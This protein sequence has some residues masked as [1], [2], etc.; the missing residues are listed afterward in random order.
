MTSV[1]GKAIT[2]AQL[3]IR[4]KSVLEGT[5]SWSDAEVGNAAVPGGISCGAHVRA[6]VLLFLESHSWKVSK[7]WKV[8][9]LKIENGI[10]I[11][12]AHVG[13]GTRT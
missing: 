4:L 3:F 7:Y 2:D 9:L 8:R 5:F 13:I 1:Q 10:H 12:D 11:S 6:A